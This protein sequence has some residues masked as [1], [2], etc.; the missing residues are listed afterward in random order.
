[1]CGICITRE[2]RKGL[3]INHRGTESNYVQKDGWFLYHSCLPIQTQDFTFAQPV[4]LKKGGYLMYNG[5]IFNVP[6]G[7]DS[8]LD[9]L[10]SLFERFPI[11]DILEVANSWDGFWSIVYYSPSGFIYAFTDP[12]GKKQLYYND[13]GEICSEIMPLVDSPEF[14]NYYKSKVFKFGYNVDDRTPWKKVRRIIPNRL[15]VFVSGKLM[16]IS[17]N[18]YFLWGINRPKK[19]IKKLL[20]ESVERRLVSRNKKIAALVSGGLDSSIIAAILAD[21][22]ADVKLYTVDNGEREYA[23]LLA[24]HIGRSLE[25]VGEYSMDD[26]ALKDAL[27]WNETPVDLGSMVPQQYIMKS[28]SEKIVL[29]GDGADELFG[30]YRRI[31]E[32]DSQLSD[33]FDELTY[34]HLPRLDRASM[35]YTKELRNPFLSHDIIKYAIGLDKFERTEKWILK[36]EFRGLVPCE[37][38]DRKK[39]PLKNPELVEDKQKYKKRVFDMFYNQ[40]F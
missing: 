17:P 37:I 1:M 29:T 40:I 21:I 38:I 31:N 16:T 12:L 8:D 13:K 24:S 11:D 32:Y 6:V 2:L 30:G 20:Y 19:T 3:M 33:I 23:E 4:K 28:I 39:L 22:G 27:L 18:D 5:E 36:E 9:Y 25:Y 10:V 34:Y 35:R 14:D 26:N 7:F 15:Y